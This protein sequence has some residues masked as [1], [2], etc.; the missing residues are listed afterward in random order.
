MPHTTP[1]H[2]KDAAAEPL[3]EPSRES[4][5]PNS[6]AAGPDSP[7]AKPG[8]KG[9]LFQALVKAGC[10]AGAAYNADAEVGAMAAEN[11]VAQFSAQL[12]L[13]FMELKQIC[14]ENAERLAEHSRKLEALAAA[15]AERDRKLDVLGARTDA[16]KMEL[17]LVWRALGILVTVLVAVFGFLFTR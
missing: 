8:E 4:S 3:R 12:Q 2:T 16:I 14:Q 11:V 17:R 13:G 5:T 6:P 7:V 9:A 15:G 10:D 1:N